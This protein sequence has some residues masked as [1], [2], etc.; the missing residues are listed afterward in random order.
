MKDKANKKEGKGKKKN[1]QNKIEYDIS[2][3]DISNE[4]RYFHIE[5]DEA[6]KSK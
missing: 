2:L 4:I 5:N 1:K 6:K 3:L